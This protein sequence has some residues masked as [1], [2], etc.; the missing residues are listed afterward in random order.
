MFQ[1]SDVMV[2]KDEVA[3]SLNIRVPLPS[4][5]PEMPEGSGSNEEIIVSKPAQEVMARKVLQLL[6]LQ[7]IGCAQC[8]R[9]TYKLYALSRDSQGIVERD[10]L[11][12]RFRMDVMC[13]SGVPAYTF[14]ISTTPVD[15]SPNVC[16]EGVGA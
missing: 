1:I 16:G 9:M 2:D 14:E 8:P 6:A 3:M 10:T 4:R 15:G 13:P 7:G 12:R 5:K 11:V